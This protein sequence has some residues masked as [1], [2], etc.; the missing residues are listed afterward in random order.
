[1]AGR[2]EKAEGV[3]FALGEVALVET[4]FGERQKDT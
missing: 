3:H 1:M 4:L 2:L